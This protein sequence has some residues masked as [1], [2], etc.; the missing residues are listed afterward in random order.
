L[1]G[2][3]EIDEVLDTLRSDWITT[4]PKV[5]R[6]QEAFAAFV[7][8]PA[9]LALNSG[10]AAMHVALAALDIGPGDAVLT[11]PMT[12]CSTAHVIEHVGAH[13]LFVDV[14]PETLN[15][16]PAKVVAALERSRGAGQPR[17][18][19]IL[20]VHLYGHPCD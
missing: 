13:P 15:L 10:T 11:T 19:A 14:E 2:Q 6:F 12:F 17:P 1:I 18:R 4:G 9:A 7:G 3:E 20:P 16:D 5:E 8:A